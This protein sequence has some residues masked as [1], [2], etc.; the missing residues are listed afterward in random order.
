MSLGS[1]NK[2]ISICCIQTLW[3]GLWFGISGGADN[4]F[5]QDQSTALNHES[6]WIRGISK[7]VFAGYNITTRGLL[8]LP[9]AC[10]WS[11]DQFS[12]DAGSVQEGQSSYQLDRQWSLV[13]RPGMHLGDGFVYML[14]SVESAHVHDVLTYVTVKDI[15]VSLFPYAHFGMGLAFAVAPQTELFAEVRFS[16]NIS[17]QMYSFVRGNE[18][19]LPTDLTDYA[20]HN[21]QLMI[22][23]SY[24]L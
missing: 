18:D 3:A 17:K 16:Q 23:I 9:I 11:W 22:G 21:T 7:R 2:W 8:R 14:A 15:T 12:H 5:L 13:V 19:P 6:A 4:T 24:D 20:I 1:Y 10:E